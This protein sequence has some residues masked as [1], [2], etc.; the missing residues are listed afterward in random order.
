M[1]KKSEK[2]E[3]V[4]TSN[5][6]VAIDNIQPREIVD[7]MKES[8]LAY[9]MS[10]IVARA[11]PDVRDGLKP[12]HRRI[13]YSMNEM[14]LKHN[15]KFVKSARITGT[16]M[17]FYHPHGN[18]A[19][20]DSMVR[21]AQDFSLR[22]PLVNGQGNFGCFTG[23]TKISLTDGRTLSFVDLVKE[24]KK[25]KKNFAYTFNDATKSIEI[26]EIKNPKITRKNASLVGITLDNGEEIKCTP[27]H[28]F[29]LRDGSYR[30][31]QFLKEGES[32]MPAY[33]R[34]STKQDDKHAVGYNMIWQPIK[35]IWDW[36]HRLADQWN[37]ENNFYS[38][39]DGRVRHHLDFNKLNNNPKNVRRM[40]WGDHWKLHYRF[41]SERHK[42]DAEYVAKLKK[43]RDDY[44]AKTENR[45]EKA[46]FLTGQNKKWWSDPGYR[47]K[48]TA[49]TKGLWGNPEY[50][51]MM[52][53]ASSKNLK[54]PWKTEKFQVLLSELK[55]KELKA[56]W[57]NPEYRRQ[58][59]EATRQ[60][61]NK[62]WSNPE[63]RRL[64]S[65][66]AKEQW[67]D[68]VKRQK[69]SEFSKKLWQNQDFRS[70]YSPDH[71]LKMAVLLWQNPETKKMHSEK[72]KKQWLDPNFR[73]KAIEAV[74]I[75]GKKFRNEHPDFM[76]EITEKA[77][78]ALK[79]KWIDPAYKRQV[80][81]SKV[82]GFTKKLINM[83][84]EDITPE[85]YEKERTNGGI[86]G[87]KCAL[88]YFSSF[89]EIL[90]E[91]KVYNHQVAEVRFLEEK[92]DVY[93][94]TI[95]GTHNFALAAGIFVHNSIDSD[96]PAAER[97]TEAR[98]SKLAE[99]VLRDIDKD[100]I[101]FKDNYDGSRK[102]PVVLPSVV[103]N[104]LINGSMGIAVGMATNIPPHNLTEVLDG[105]VYMIGNPDTGVEG[106]TQFIKGPDFPTGGSIY[107]EKDI[108][109]TYASGRG[110]IIMRAKTEIVESKRG[111][112]IIVT[113]IPYQVNKAELIQRIAG[114]A[115]GKDKRID[116]IKDIRDES[117]KDGIRVVVD[118]K[119]DA[120]PK[121]VL[122][123]LFKYTELQKTF[124]V[125][126]LA[127]VD[128]IQPQTLNLKDILE[129]FIEHRR[130]VVTRR[131]QFELRKAEERAHILEGLKKALDHIDAI[132]KLIRASES[133]DEALKNLMKKF[134]FSERQATAIL[135]MKLRALAGLER[136]KVE[137]EL[138]EK[139]A[140]IAY[141]EDLLA[142]P[143]K[144]MG[145]VK[146]E[147]IEIKT[148][149]G[150]ERR[151][152]VVK[153]ALREIGEE[154]LMPEENSLFMITRGGYIKRLSPEILKIQKRG[155]KGLI[156][157]DTKEEDIVSQ[158]FMANTHDNILFFTNSGRAFQTK[159]YEVPESS[160]QSK[161][162]A[163]VN[164]LNISS[165]EAVTAVVPIPKQTKGMYLFMS[166]KGGVVKKVAISDFEKVRT[167]GLISIKLKKDDELKWVESTSG[168][169][170]II[171]VT[172][173][174]NSIRFKEGDVRPMG[175]SASGV[176]GVRLEKE[177][178]VV[179]MEVIPSS[180]SEKDHKLLV[181]M[182]KGYGKRTELRAYKIQYRGGRGIMTAKITVKTG[183]II[184]AH[185]VN[186]EHK[187]IIA[188]SQRGQ[189]IKTSLGSI[190]VLG[191]ATQGVRI[192]KL[193]AGDSVASV[194]VV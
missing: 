104:L 48:K 144:I 139:K 63:H 61:S 76:Q 125:N 99:E 115:T 70:K 118:L 122:N 106:L 23:E 184:S 114:L 81:R 7:E 1:I 4:K 98:L 37:V 123:Q 11:L 18:A 150:D 108:L 154:E 137:N 54:K 21:M 165:S 111:F 91:A 177:A 155:G 40:Q 79:K 85:I 140:L 41:A 151:T 8:Y 127:L 87:I 191:R 20:Y 159:G 132:I 51:E 134:L 57:Q 52:R 93:D 22:Y 179:S 187:E 189:V 80:M 105:L 38:I 112:Q 124:H 178:R 17:G 35:G 29:M 162:K 129:K 145:V 182:E 92:A 25:G 90:Q 194:V 73:Q 82:L 116:G 32:L 190:S 72:A 26:A 33:F 109:N 71:F 64:I 6:T 120:F 152:K 13:L 153:S 164:F 180:I 128:G 53:L 176:I 117:D 148:K 16:C 49:M 31:A 47:A 186:P 107:N 167:N 45:E 133:Q 24:N 143:K 101:D 95:K 83:R 39:R 157:M 185:I 147:F 34:I 65:Q 86:P 175:R 84:G 170:E 110:P 5:P 27:D 163:I 56:R 14:G 36:A 188:V 58:I 136:K 166:T 168:K 121:K 113:E 2:D 181:V 158:F 169:D 19:I 94:L 15:T 173:D 160:R 60:M 42:N 46:R 62:L 78:A 103:P 9:A 74:K 12:V 66:K 77:N 131:S 146:E 192:M 172:S 88:E 3:E 30:E 171:L 174:G 89:Q 130:I 96:P 59:T 183:Q 50:K 149:Y 55:S 44:W 135:E 141:L 193:S 142:H 102:E 100:T 156:G 126:M 10:V 69:Q 75:S 161:G 97:Y 138:K 68:P 67:L 43:G 28:R 119:Q